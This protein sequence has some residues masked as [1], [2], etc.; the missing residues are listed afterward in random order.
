MIYFNKVRDV[1]SPTQAY[2]YPAGTD[3]YVPNYNQK[4]KHDLIERN[5]NTD[6]YSLFTKPDSDVMT[7]TSTVLCRAKSKFSINKTVLFIEFLCSVHVIPYFKITFFLM[8]SCKDQHF[9]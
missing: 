8:L 2:N 9:I 1:K 5:H 6:E 3:F 7:I 4:F